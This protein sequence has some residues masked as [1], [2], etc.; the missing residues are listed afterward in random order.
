MTRAER[1]AFSDAALDNM[2]LVDCAE[3]MFESLDLVGTKA[4]A[5]TAEQRKDVRALLALFFD[6]T[7][8]KTIKLHGGKDGKDYDQERDRL[9]II[10][11]LRFVFGF[12]PLPETQLAII[13]ARV[14]AFKGRGAR[15]PFSGIG[16]TSS[17]VDVI[18]QW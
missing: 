14:Q 3:V 13:A 10:A 6:E 18:T 15:S 8:E 12:D 7:T 5:L 17:S 1:A 11:R 9:S 4:Q 16:A 2:D